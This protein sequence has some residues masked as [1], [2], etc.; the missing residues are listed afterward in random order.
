M[1]S[2]ST[3]FQNIK[4]IL[5]LLYPISI[6]IIRKQANKTLGIFCVDIVLKMNIFFL[7]SSESVFFNLQQAQ[8]D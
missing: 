3:K 8:F 2:T 4:I 7:I 1:K 6:E 5:D